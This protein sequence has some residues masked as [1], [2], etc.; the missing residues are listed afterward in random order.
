[1]S[2]IFRFRAEDLLQCRF[3]ISPLNETTDALR[4]LM[5]PGRAA[6]HLPWHREARRILPDLRIGP[7]LAV[8]AVRGY[9]PDFLNPAPGGPFTEIETELERVRATSPL[10]V[11]AELA[12]CLRRNPGVQASWREHPELSGDPAG[13]RDRLAGLLWRAWQA[14][15]EPWWP[16]LRDVLDADITFRSR[17]LASSG[18]AA[19][20]NDLE[21]RIS[22][23]DGVLRFVVA[24]ADDELDLAGQELV[25][26]PSVF[27]WPGGAIMYDPP[28][29]I[30]PARGIGEIWHPPRRSG[31]DLAALIGKTR[32]TVLQALA[33]PAS[34]T[35]LADRTG[36]PVSSVSEHL[37]VLRAAGLV[38]TSRTGRFLLH[39]RTALG[40]ALSAGSSRLTPAKE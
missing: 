23:R 16:R 31:G 2:I 3:A 1:M 25:L 19:T 18:L 17:Q 8:L 10:R 5:L 36:V 24:T 33:E 26:M 4:S 27:A 34:T 6:Y 30:Y 22:W 14:L 7:L 32:A 39:R 38:S 28:G 12:E 13:I 37:S 40:V 29:V 15:V 21:P 20:I 11:A 35:G 9:Q